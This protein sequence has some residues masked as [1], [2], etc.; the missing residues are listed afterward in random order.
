[1]PNPE[2]EEAEPVT[3]NEL[4]YV[5]G[6]LF[7]DCNMEFK[8]PMQMKWVYEKW[9]HQTTSEKFPDLPKKI[10]ETYKENQKIAQEQNE[11]IGELTRSKNSQSRGG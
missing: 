3:R 5:A 10:A 1:M 4:V 7:R 8:R 9:S 2:D 11:K 6:R